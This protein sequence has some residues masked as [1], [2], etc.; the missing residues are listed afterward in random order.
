MH[1]SVRTGVAAALLVSTLVAAG[2]AEAKVVERIVA[3]VNKRILLL[4][5]V[6]ERVRP[7]VPQLQQIPDMT[8][9]K[10]RLKQLR[11]QVLNHLIDEALIRQEASKL[12]LKVSDKDLELAI[13]DVMRKNKL[14]REQLAAA[15]RQEGK[16][17]AAYKQKILR[18]QLL[19]MR[20]VNVQVRSRV[21]VSKDEI[22]ALYQKN[23]R[24]LGVETKLRARHI[25]VVIPVGA[26]GKKVMDRKRYAVSLAA[27]GRKKGA[28][29][30][31]LAKKYSEDSVTRTDG[32][33]L[34]YFS[35]GT[36]PANIEAVV[37]AMK[38]GDIRGPMRT[39]RGYHVIKLVDRKESS[40]RS[41]AD[42]KEE[43]RNQIY[44]KKVEKATK[45][46][47]KELRKRS[48]VDIK[49]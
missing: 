23:L 49:V 40:A 22:K 14:T 26:S 9:R 27:Q 5:Q 3:V 45:A 8:M 46:W 34:G 18:P 29:F 11:R 21:A 38:K 30:A 43:L 36:L 42:V 19:R 16:S 17:I 10:Q 20:V 2:G 6:N 13:K 44:M 41:L 48:Y 33:D 1:Q 24:A 12:K 37:F 4:S 39:E 47:L 35:R 31:A 7:L 28:D 32:G 25:F 15:L